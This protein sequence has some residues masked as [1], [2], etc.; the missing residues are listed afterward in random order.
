MNLV[1]ITNDRIDV[2]GS[3]FLGMT[4]ACAR[5]HD[6]KFDPIPTSDYWAM[7]GMFGS[8]VEPD[9]GPVLDPDHTAETDAERDYVA[10]RSELTAEANRVQQ[11]HY[12]ELIADVRTRMDLY[13]VAAASEAGYLAKQTFDPPIQDRAGRRFRHWLQRTPD[14]SVAYTLDQA[15]RIAID[16]NVA[17]EDFGRAI[18]GR[19]ERQAKQGSHAVDPLILEHVRSAEVADYRTLLEWA[20]R[21]WIRLVAERDAGRPLSEA[22]RQFVEAF[23]VGLNPLTRPIEDFDEV[24]AQKARREVARAK[25]ELT[26]LAIEHPG[27]PPRAMVLVE[28]PTPTKSPVYIRGNIGRPGP[29]VDRRSP[30]IVDPS[31]AAFADTGSGRDELAAD[32]VDPDNPLAARVAVNRIWQHYFGRGLVET[33][34]DFGTRGERPTHPQ[35]LDYLAGRLIGAGWS[36]KAIHREILLSAAYR[37]SS[38]PRPELD[39]PTNALLSHQ[40]R[41]RVDFESMREALMARTGRLDETIGGKPVD[42]LSPRRAI[43]QKVDRNYMPDDW[44][45]F[46]FPSPDNTIG[47]RTQTTVPQQAL[48]QLNSPLPKRAA[49]AAVAAAGTYRE[50]FR[51]L[52]ARDPSPREHDLCRAFLAD[53]G[54]LRQLAQTLLMSNEFHF[55]D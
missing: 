44:L 30:Q 46:D 54:N 13:L 43:Y 4:V 39:D 55:V 18:R 7:Y 35:L 47:S 28:K 9:L 36:T 12:D 2:T 25:G 42:W 23:F 5:C 52:L 27:A 16:E 41:R 37:Q 33:A 10:K 15:G 8:T 3:G 32:I 49:E 48:Y 50:L 6:H 34:S 40:N 19:L 53:G 24:F 22:E 17:A 20:G 31:A 45:T 51:L 38:Q 1:E 14:S 21:E 29:F 11:K 26:K